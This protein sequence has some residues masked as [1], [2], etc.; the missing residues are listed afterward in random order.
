MFG[1][2]GGSY[3]GLTFVRPAIPEEAEWLEVLTKGGVV[4]FEL[5][6]G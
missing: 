3:H 6:P 2:S 1:G 4:R 5:A